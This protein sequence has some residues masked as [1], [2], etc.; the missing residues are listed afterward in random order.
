MN[1]TLKSKI[2]LIT[3]MI[4][5]GTIGIFRK[6][7]PLPS[8][9]VAA[10][11]GLTGAL[12]LFTLTY[13]KGNKISIKAIKNN[14]IPLLFS[15]AFIGINWIL[16]F[17]AYEY[18]TVATATLCYYMAPLIVVLAATIFFKETLTLKKV[19]CIIVALSGIVL[20]SSVLQDSSV[21]SY[22]IKGILFGLGAATFYAGVI[23]INKTIKNISIYDQTIVQLAIAGIIVLPYS[24]MTIDM[25]ELEWNIKIVFLLLLVG[26]IHTGITYAMYFSTITILKTQTV[27]LFSYIDPII[28]IILSTILLSENIGIY[29]IIGA[30]LI[31]GATFISEINEKN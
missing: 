16:L 13:I 11:R 15:G 3:S 1:N 12:F 30:I 20:V 22:D 8:S 9:V 17:E 26:I 6:Y 5:F 7:I 25:R 19:I 27:A 21:G 31:L 23:L 10:T 28:A 18:T 14:L 2:M 29:D 24:F 4:I